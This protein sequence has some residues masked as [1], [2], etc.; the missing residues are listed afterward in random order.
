[1]VLVKWLRFCYGEDQ[2]FSLSECPACLAVVLQLNLNCKDKLKAL[3]EAHM[4]KISEKNIEEG[5][6][7]LHECA[8]VYEECRKDGMS[9]IDIALAKKLLTLDNMKRHPVIV[10]KYL[11]DLP[12]IYLDFVEY[13]EKQDDPLNEVHIRLN[14]AKRNSSMSDEDKYEMLKRIN[15][16]K[17]NSDELKQLYS[18]GVFKCDSFVEKILENMIDKEQEIKR[19][20]QQIEE[21]QR[22]C[23][24]LRRQIE[25]VM[26]EVR[27]NK[28]TIEEVRTYSNNQV[29]HLQDEIRET[30]RTTKAQIER[31][32]EAIQG[33][34][35]KE[36]DTKDKFDYL[37]W[38]SHTHTDEYGYWSSSHDDDSY[39]GKN[40]FR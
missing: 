31:Q 13:S 9:R 19:Q 6:K 8:V 4:M 23:D 27:R 36:K 20:Q 3:I 39:S 30:K 34:R 11:M 10:D 5:M 21:L 35:R 14:Y 28:S 33:F 12:Q 32:E 40:P 18:F 22:N 1:M 29:S 15:P 2:T 24:T 17:M 38:C 37:Y 7:I 16:G 25:E 26:R